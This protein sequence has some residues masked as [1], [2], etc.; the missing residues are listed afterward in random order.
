[1]RQVGNQGQSL[2]PPG[3]RR[4]RDYGLLASA[5]TVVLLSASALASPDAQAET[6]SHQAPF[7]WGTAGR[8]CH[9]PK[10]T[11][12]LQTPEQA[13]S[14]APIN[15]T[16]RVSPFPRK[17]RLTLQRGEQRRW[18]TLVS[19]KAT[20]RFHLSFTAPDA[21]VT[22]PLRVALV[23]EGKTLATSAV[24]KL[25]MNRPDRT[26]S[27]NG[28]SS[29]A[30]PQKAAPLEVTSS[31]ITLSIGSAASVTNATPLT[32][33]E[34]LDG[35]ASG[36]E[37]GVSAGLS[38]GHPF[39]AASSL[40]ATGSMTLTVSGAGCTPECGEQFVLHVPVTVTSVAASAGTLEGFTEPSPD[41]VEGAVGNQLADEVLIMLG[42][43][44]EP[45]SRAEAEVAA[46]TVGGIVSGG[47]FEEGIYQIRWLTPQ[48]LA[49]RITEL[50]SQPSV[51]AVTPSYVGM[52]E[53]QSTYAS[54]LGP[55]YDQ[56]YWTW[57]Y[58]QVRATQAWAQSTGSDVTVGIVD[59]G[60]AF[61][62]SPDI[63]VSKT[64]NPIA[65]PGA[66][67]T[68]V[69]GLACGKAHAGG[70]VGLAWGCPIATTYVEASGDKYAD[71]NVMAAMQRVVKSGVRIVNISMGAASGCATQDSRNEIEQW[72]THSKMFF[73][74][75]LVGTGSNV[76]WT[77][78]AGNNCMSG[79]S[80]PWAAN[81]DLPNVIDVAA[82]NADGKLASFSNYGV[83]LAAPGGVEPGFPAIDLNASCN[84]DS[85]LNGGRCGLLS[86]TVG[87]CASGYCAERGEMAGTSMAS[88]IVAGIAALVA[89]EHTSFT[90]SQIT[91]CI[92]STAGTEGVGSTGPPDG[93]PGGAY[94]DPPLPYS[95]API[96]IVNAAAAVECAPPDVG[97]EGEPEGEPG[98]SWNAAEIPVPPGGQADSGQAKVYAACSSNGTCV[99]GGS[100]LIPGPEYRGSIVMLSDGIWGSIEA[101]VPAGG[102]PGSGSAYAPACSANGNCVMLGSYITL[103]GEARNSVD[104]LS[105]GVWTSIDLPVPA[106]AAAGSGQPEGGESPACSPDGT[107]VIGGSYEGSDGE[108]VGMIDTY[109][110][111]TWTS[112]DLPAPAGGTPLSRINDVAC[113][114]NGTCVVIGDYRT[115]SGEP[116]QMIDTLFNGAWS[117][118]DMPVPAGGEMGPGWSDFPEI[119]CTLNGTCMLGSGYV[120]ANKGHGM[121]DMLRNGH[122]TSIDVPVP[123]GGE[124]GSGFTYGAGCSAHGVCVVLT[125]YVAS[126]GQRKSSIDTWSGG[127][128]R[129]IDV[130]VPAGGRDGPQPGGSFGGDYYWESGPPVCSSG[131]TCVVTRTYW[132][133]AEGQQREMIATLFDG[134]WSAVDV[135]FPAGGKPGWGNSIALP[136]CGPGGFCVMGGEY[137]TT[138]N[139]WRGMI[140]LL[141]NG[142]WS[143]IEMPTPAGGKTRRGGYPTCSSSGTCVFINSFLSSGG[144]ERQMLVTNE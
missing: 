77:F 112:I 99:M 59:V 119:A 19:A 29:P 9:C 61:A 125:S 46:A 3:Q 95:G 50:E 97:E 136:S 66:H 13:T 117:S 64:L 98:D 121:I 41:R 116:H 141:S 48:N 133:L 92:T 142:T 110:D 103:G 100:Y 87:P 127:T 143:S 89:S 24:R 84:S 33:I 45:G 91:S 54:I 144:Q 135:P 79:P 76:V 102:K 31:P 109:S 123:A 137:L 139:Q 70:M 32:S 96:P 25:L 56:P 130:P 101:P 78:S 52:T 62:G 104:T 132:T 22:W 118:I 40:A 6:A 21:A 73:R 68:N 49:A 108:P 11:I 15:V 18:V 39:V 105:G 44:E 35:P 57:R 27:S 34:T 134:V 122:W 55:A 67:A 69:A 36:A 111:G 26:P 47:L 80:S 106:G 131:G 53:S 82:T 107:C 10:W 17:A 126:G 90:A 124:V 16:G 83:A 23:R 128:W 75:L 63:N 114:S 30:A 138:G 113:T 129:A 1:M 58:D 115:S 94:A 12:T 20:R 37:P 72:I 2:K 60:N 65:V 140:D 93:Q 51:T 120:S 8:N 5:I 28:P 38:K 74:R 7:A 88:P 43:I 14:G 4:S 85:I 86:A 42:S 81:S 71:A